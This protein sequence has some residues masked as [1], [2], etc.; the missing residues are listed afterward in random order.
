MS[1]VR[2]NC[3]T[4]AP[5]SPDSATGHYSTTSGS[6]Y[7]HHT[8]RDTMGVDKQNG[9]GHGFFREYSPASFLTNRNALS[10]VALM[11]LSVRAP[12]ACQRCCVRRVR[13]TTL[14]ITQYH[15]ARAPDRQ[16]RRATSPEE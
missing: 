15:A 12:P 16:G 9:L 5:V 13:G 11:L 14:Q 10:A 2:A 1:D 8:L 6:L 3:R 4:C 7:R